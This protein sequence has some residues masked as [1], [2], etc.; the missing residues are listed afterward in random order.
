MQEEQPT[1]APTLDEV[2]RFQQSLI[3][4]VTQGTPVSPESKTQV[5]EHARQLE[6]WVRQV[7]PKSN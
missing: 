7:R 5:S 2:L 1:L 3:T 4:L 6:V